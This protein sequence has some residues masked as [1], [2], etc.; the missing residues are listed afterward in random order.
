MSKKI[1]ISLPRY[2]VETIEK[3]KLYFSFSKDSI[4]NR[5]IWG[6][7]FNKTEKMDISILDKTSSTSFNLNN[8]NYSLFYDMLKIS[9]MEV[10]NEFIRMLMI[11]YSNMHPSLREKVLNLPLFI[12]LEFCIKNNKKIKILYEKEVIDI[13]PNY[14]ERNKITL[15]NNLN[16]NLKE[17]Q[18]ILQLKNIEILKIY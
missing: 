17:K 6:L 14:F 11:K 8:K 3:D 15:Y 1:K 18:K 2:V 16:V 5:I 13:S 4:Y 10:E 7:G 12:D 9:N